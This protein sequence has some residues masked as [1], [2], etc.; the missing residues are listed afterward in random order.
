MSFKFFKLHSWGKRSADMTG[1]ISPQHTS[2]HL[3]SDGRDDAGDER[4]RGNQADPR[5]PSS[6]GADDPDC[7]HDSQRIRQG[8]AGRWHERTYRQAHQHGDAQEHAGVV[9]EAVI[10]GN[11]PCCIECGKGQGNAADRSIPLLTH[12]TSCGRSC[13]LTVPELRC[14]GEAAACSNYKEPLQ[15]PSRWRR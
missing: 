15:S 10:H 3:N 9:H 5:L 4:L 1:L 7:R 12:L 11:A 13:K 8:C 14:G 6:G 2:P